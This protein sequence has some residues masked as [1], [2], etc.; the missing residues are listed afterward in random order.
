MKKQSL[1]LFRRA[2]WIPVCLMAVIAFTA[3]ACSDDD[4]EP[5]VPSP[6]TAD[7]TFGAGE[8]DTTIVFN[9]YSGW[10]AS[11]TKSD[12]V[13]IKSAKTGNA[14]EVKMEIHISENVT[15]VPRDAEIHINDGRSAVNIYRIKQ[16]PASRAINFSKALNFVQRDTLFTDTVTV[17]ANVAW[18]VGEKPE[19]VKSW[20]KVNPELM[21]E[22]GVDTEIE[23][24]FIA[25]N[26]K[27]TTTKMTGEISF[28]DVNQNNYPLPVEFAGFTPSITFDVAE[29]VL[30]PN[31]GSSEVFNGKLVVASN[32]NWTV[33][34]AEA[35]F[36]GDVSKAPNPIGNALK[37][38]NIIWVSVDPAKLT[39]DEQTGV[40]HFK[41]AATNLDIPLN[42]KFVGTGNDYINFEREKIFDKAF[43]AKGT[44][45]NTGEPIP[46]T[47]TTVDFNVFAAEP[48]DFII[49]KYDNGFPWH[50][51]AWWAGVEEVTP[52]NRSA[53][54]SGTYTL[55]VQDRYQGFEAD[56]ERMAMLF[57]VPKGR[58][59]DDLFD[60]D[61]DDLKPEWEGKGTH[62]KQK[63]LV[64]DY[65]MTL[66][67]ITEGSTVQ[68][69]KAGEE[70]PLNME[71][72]CETWSVYYDGV[73]VAES[74]VDWVSVVGD[75]ENGWNLKV[76]PN[77]TGKSRKTEVS[78]RAW[79]GD[80]VE[81]QVLITF[82]VSQ[83]K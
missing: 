47:M 15:F 58:T 12:V 23:L 77:D 18:E 32:V 61:S 54:K 63:G 69:A 5:G 76:K 28:K 46:G 7:L 60:G 3:V 36:V 26:S 72:D 4:N 71:T 35:P 31:E 62:F 6:F 49:I 59:V 10:K 44:D 39:T 67:D 16:T 37:A 70:K 8:I 9:A 81:E 17:I 68:I 2:G 25:D 43:D 73:Y 56:K 1:K 50:Q 40:L 64:I 33:D 20:K 21:P 52:I 11:V 19:W 14:G 24:V 51:E 80:G 41:D 13:E 79:R 65:Y 38:E 82:W 78:F 22:D 34:M 42:V 83:D 30:E 66:G 55:C 48:V 74:N 29:L 53:I 45:E 57:V 27:F 75:N